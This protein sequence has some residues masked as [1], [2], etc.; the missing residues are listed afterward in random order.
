M[1]TLGSLSLS[2]PAQTGDIVKTT[3]TY[4]PASGSALPGQVIDFRWYTVGVSTKMQTPEV[5]TSGS[6]NSSGVVV[7]QYTLPV[8]RSESYTVYVIATTGGLTN[9]EGWQS[10]TVAP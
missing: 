8:V 5:T 7:S 3:A 6:T 10:V 2:A 1:S 4:K 9:S